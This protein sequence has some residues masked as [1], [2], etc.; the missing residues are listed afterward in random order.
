MAAEKRSRGASRN[1]HGRTLRRPVFSNLFRNRLSQGGGFEQVVTST[2]EYLMASWPQELA[3]LNWQVINAP[4]ITSDDQLV[5]R[6]GIR[7]STMTIFIYRLPIERMG[8]HRRGDQ[9]HERMHIE[10]NVFAAVGQ[11]VDKDPWQLV[12]ERYR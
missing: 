12:P 6:W 7:K 1:R 2:C 4:A 8:H 5:R 9:L 11:L 10:E 3:G